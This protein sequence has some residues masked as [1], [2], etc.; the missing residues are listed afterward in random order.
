MSTSVMKTLP[1]SNC[2]VLQLSFIRVSSLESG[3]NDGPS[4]F[5]RDL[6]LIISQKKRSVTRTDLKQKKLEDIVCL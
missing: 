5:R 6:T 3:L 2:S 1:V 4:V